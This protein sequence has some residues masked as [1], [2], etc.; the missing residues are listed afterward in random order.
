MLCNPS[1][2]HGV[3]RQAALAAS[4]FAPQSCVHCRWCTRVGVAMFGFV[5]QQT[6]G[7][8]ETH[9]NPRQG[10]WC[11][12]VPAQ[13]CVLYDYV[14]M[15]RRQRGVA[16]CMAFCRADQ[17][18]IGRCQTSQTSTES[19][20]QASSLAGMVW[21]C[22]P[23]H[24]WMFVSTKVWRLQSTHIGRPAP[25]AVH[26]QGSPCYTCM[27]A[28]DKGRGGCDCAAAVVCG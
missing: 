24:A 16:R 23:V 11:V 22:V 4:V 28:C 27:H 6:C 10:A 12:H 19:R 25:H 21:Q 5:Q 3:K 18:V 9:H 15:F 13:R 14:I 7:T 20:Q 2:Q 8:V 1:F 26:S 17:A